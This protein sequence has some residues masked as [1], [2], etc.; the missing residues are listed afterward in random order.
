MKTSTRTDHSFPMLQLELDLIVNQDDVSSVLR[1]HT[2]YPLSLLMN[3][4]QWTGMDEEEGFVLVPDNREEDLLI[5]RE[6]LLNVIP[7]KT[8]LTLDV[9]KAFLKSQSDLESHIF[10]TRSP[11]VK[12]FLRRLDSRIPL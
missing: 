5:K 4:E 3:N 2:P 7:E 12:R 8:N 1:K 6:W 9:L 11:S 10:L